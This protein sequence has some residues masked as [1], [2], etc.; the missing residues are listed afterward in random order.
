MTVT[1]EKAEAAIR[2][3]V[4]D[5]PNRRNPYDPGS[6]QCINTG[7]RGSHCIAAEAL[8]ILGYGN[9]LPHK[10]EQANQLAIEGLLSEWGVTTDFDFGAIALLSEA[11]NIFDGGGENGDYRPKWSTGLNKLDAQIARIK[12]GG[13]DDD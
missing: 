9:A 10:D 1:I 4:A 2:L 7:V 11:Q 13:S 8:V 5:H 12:S 6:G 3:A